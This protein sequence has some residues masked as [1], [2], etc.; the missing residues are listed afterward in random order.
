MYGLQVVEPEKVRIVT[1][2]SV[3]AR[4][5]RVYYRH[6][7]G[8]LPGTGVAVVEVG[9][10][11]AVYGDARAGEWTIL[12]IYNRAWEALASLAR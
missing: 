12:M 3:C 6:H 2:D 4:A 5:A 8:P 7:L 10:A 9:E 1:D 11:Y